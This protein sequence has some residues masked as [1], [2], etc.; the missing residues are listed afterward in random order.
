MGVLVARHTTKSGEEFAGE[1]ITSIYWRT[2]Y[3]TTMGLSGLS[4]WSCGDAVRFAKSRK[5]LT[6]PPLRQCEMCHVPMLHPLLRRRV[7]ERGNVHLHQLLLPP[8]DVIGVAASRE[9][10]KCGET[11]TT[12]P[13][14]I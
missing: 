1:L 2:A 10:T 4:K 11:W 3:G 5:A 6:G 8:L 14:K 12:G 9:R 7:R 13:E